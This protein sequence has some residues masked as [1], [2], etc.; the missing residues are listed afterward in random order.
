MSPNTATVVGSTLSCV[1]WAV[2]HAALTGQ[3]WVEVAGWVMDTEDS[4]ND[5]DM[6][7]ITEQ[8]GRPDAMVLDRLECS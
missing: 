2:A 1:R 5:C 7:D 3:C 6:W 4:L 8:F